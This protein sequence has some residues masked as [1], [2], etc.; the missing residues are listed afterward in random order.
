[1]RRFLII[2]IAL[3][4]VLLA[5]TSAARGA[6]FT[7]DTVSG[8]MFANTAASFPTDTQSEGQNWTDPPFLNETKFADSFAGFGW[9]TAESQ[10]NYASAATTISGSGAVINQAFLDSIDEVSSQTESAIDILFTVPV[11]TQ[12]TLNATVTQSLS[13]PPFLVLTNVTG[14]N[15]GTGSSGFAFS[16]TNNQTISLTGILTPAQY[17]LNGH[18]KILDALGPASGI[19]SIDSNATFDFLLTLTPIPEPSAFVLG[20]FGVI[21]LVAYGWRRRRR[22]E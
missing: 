7:L 21:G 18:V 12:Y 20:A 14:F 1:M 4:A 3:P 10:L 17:R 6:A 19:L 15:W 8:T 9:A 5:A 16:A 11:M 13:N 2:L 22:R